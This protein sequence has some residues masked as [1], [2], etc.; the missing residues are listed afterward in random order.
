MPFTSLTK[1]SRQ[2]Q[3]PDTRRDDFFDGIEDWFERQHGGLQRPA[4]EADRLARHTARGAAQAGHGDRRGAKRVE[5]DGAADRADG[6]GARCRAL[7]ARFR[8]GSARRTPI[9]STGSRSK[10]RPGG[11]SRLASAPLDVGPTLR[12]DLFEQVPPASSPRPRS[13]SAR[14]PGSTSSSRGSA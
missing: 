4:S 11:A 3:R 10:R 12:R 13:A 5:T 9:P 7:A 6:G 2:V 8:P 14:R 1:R